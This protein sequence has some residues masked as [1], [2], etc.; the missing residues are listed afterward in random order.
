MIARTNLL[1]QYVGDHGFGGYAGIDAI[2]ALFDDES[3]SFGDYE[4]IGNLQLGAIYQRT[5]SPTLDIGARVGVILPTSSDA[6]FEPL[7]HMAY[8]GVARPSDLATAVPDAT[9]L[10]LGLSPTFHRGAFIARADVGLDVAVRDDHDV[11]VLGHLNLGVGVQS[12][13]ITA[14][15]ELQTVADL[16]GGD[17]DVHDD[18]GLSQRLAHTG[19]LAVRYHAAHVAPFLALSS[20]LDDGSRG[21]VLTVTAGLT[22]AF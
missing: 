21:E 18:G 3:R 19:G 7:V 12:G 16:G 10:R 13:P 5:L 9:W 17:E 2:M 4:A 20:P 1:G 11:P 22:A 15:A 14:T 8:T 6:G